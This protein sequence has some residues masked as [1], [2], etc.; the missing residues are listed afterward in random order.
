MDGNTC[1]LLPR[2]YS[3]DA[4]KKTIRYY[5]TTLRKVVDNL[6]ITYHHR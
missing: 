6:E 3:K 2:L 5:Q 1:E 4:V